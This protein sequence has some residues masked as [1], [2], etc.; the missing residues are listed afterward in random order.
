MTNFLALENED[1]AQRSQELYD[2]YC[3][4]VHCWTDRLF[5]WLLVSQWLVAV[6]VAIWISPYAWEGSPSNVHSDVWSAVLVGL[7]VISLPVWRAIVAPGQVSTRLSIAVAQA[8]MSAL[9]IHLTGGHF[10]THFHEFCSLAV[11]AFYRDWRVLAA[12]SATGLLDHLVR[13]AVVPESVFGTTMISFWRPFEHAGWAFVEDVFLVIAGSHSLAE[14]RRHAMREAELELNNDAT[15]KLI[16]DRTSEL[17]TSVARTRSIL[18]AALDAIVSFDSSGRIIEFN[19]AAE[20]T[21]GYATTAVLGEPLSKLVGDHDC[22]TSDQNL[23]TYLS[24]ERTRALGRRIEAEALH[25]DGH[26]FPVE[27][28]IVAIGTTNLTYTA[29]IRDISDRREVEEAQLK[30]KQQAEEASLAKS[31]FLA[32]MSHE[33]RTPLN[34]VIGMTELL[35]NTSLDERQLQFVRACQSSGRALLDLINDV[36]DV[37][38]IE[39]GKLELDCHDFDLEQLIRDTTDMVWLRAHEK[40][41]ELLCEFDR[42]ARQIYSGDSTRL[43]QVLVNLLTNA[44][45]FTDCGEIVLGVNVV[46]RNDAVATLKFSVRDTGIGIPPDRVNRLFQQFSQ[47]DSSTTRKY[48]GTGL[49]LAICKHLVNAMGGSIGVESQVGEG[50][51][52]WFT[53]PLTVR[54][55]CELQSSQD[56]ALLD[57]RRVMI[58]DD[59]ATN[60]VII[61]EQTRSWGMIPCVAASVDEAVRVYDRARSEQKSI[62]LIISDFHMPDKTGVDLAR[63]LGTQGALPPFI[64]LGSTITDTT[65]VETIQSIGIRQQLT[66]PVLSTQLYTAVQSMLQSQRPPTPEKEVTRE[67][68]SSPAP[69]KP[70]FKGELLIAEDNAV[71]T[72]YV[73]SLLNQAGYTTQTANNGLQAVLAVRT[74]HFALVLM[75][76]Q[77]P[78][79]DGY[80]ATRCIR[81]LESKGRLSGHVPIIALTANAIKGDAERC[82]EA[83]MDAYLSKP[84][85][86]QQLLRLVEKLSRPVEIDGDVEES[87][88]EIPEDPTPEPVASANAQSAGQRADYSPSEEN[89]QAKLPI[90][91][92]AE[93]PST[94]V[95]PPIDTRALLNRCMGS[96][97]FMESLLSELESTGLHHVSEIERNF[98]LKEPTETANAAH[99]LKGAA[100]ILSAEAVR[101]LASDIEQCGRSGS[102]DGIEA[103]IADLRLEMERCLKY[104][105][106]VKQSALEIAAAAPAGGKR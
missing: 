97:E 15:E 6:A 62:D 63:Q 49:G 57:G 78:E 75:D 50:T 82:L 30:A 69:S 52:F 74:Q 95:N 66:K 23:V 11:L 71:N 21:F 29:F 101:Q 22:K 13:G 39:A 76:C 77:M 40:G 19:P 87:I 42:H 59:N 5:G 24:T 43:R 65:F 51:T 36:L 2:Q 35:M 37:S 1:L 7:A 27:V 106:I 80:E 34:G 61:E 47:V 90:P 81:N 98:G 68:T 53:L 45:K 26:R 96:V 8:L 72:L 48:G 9:F 31:Q 58:V 55:D 46:Q 38:K 91:V 104:I 33:L 67:Q 17:K 4:R 41:L 100:G 73:T 60:R 99:A 20:S 79:L 86:P 94:D 28:A 3:K 56:G 12:A 14:T 84:F 54:E 102:L 10:E 93:K 64:L 83:G 25:H 18:D 70:S 16:A 92:E 32:S 44:E 105:P 89:S 85:D 88:D 103:A